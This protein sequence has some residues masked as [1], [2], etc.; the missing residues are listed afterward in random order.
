VEKANKKDVV[1]KAKQRVTAEKVAKAKEAAKKAKEAKEA[2]VKKAA[3]DQAATETETDTEEEDKEDGAM[4]ECA[5]DG[6]ECLRCKKRNQTR[7]SATASRSV[8]EGP[9]VVHRRP[10]CAANQAGCS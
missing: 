9:N 6:S 1:E 10:Q 8:S 7:R 2:S 5:T 3:A 4:K